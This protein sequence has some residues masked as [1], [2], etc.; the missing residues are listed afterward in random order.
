MC[1]SSPWTGR[2]LATSPAPGPTQRPIQWASDGSKLYVLDAT[3]I[4]ARVFVVDVTSGR[5]QLVH[6]IHARDSSG[7]YAIEN[8]ALTPDGAAYAYDY[9]QFQSDLYV[10][11]G[12]R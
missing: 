7:V 9:Q 10:V 12:L 3:E 2:R 4:P 8:V 1:A 6:E 5:R 11:D